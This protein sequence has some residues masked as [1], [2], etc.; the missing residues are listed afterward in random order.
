M[1]V[2]VQKVYTWE[3]NIP[4]CPEKLTGYGNHLYAVEKGWGQFEIKSFGVAGDR[5]H[6]LKEMQIHLCPFHTKEFKGFLFDDSN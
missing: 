6:F 5:E 2:R 4:D 3:C 1:S